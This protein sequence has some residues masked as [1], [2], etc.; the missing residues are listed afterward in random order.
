[1]K[2]FKHEH[3][4]LHWAVFLLTVLAAALVVAPRV[5]ADI[6]PAIEYQYQGTPVEQK[7]TQGG[8]NR[9]N[10]TLNAQKAK[11]TFSSGNAQKQTAT[12]TLKGHH[13]D[14]YGNKTPVNVQTQ[15]ALPK[16]DIYTKAAGGLMGASVAGGALQ[17]Q[18]DGI[19]RALAAG[20]YTTAT[21][22]AVAGLLDGFKGLG[23]S[24]L[25]GGIT[26]AESLING[27][28]QGKQ[29]ASVAEAVAHAQAQ[30]AAEVREANEANSQGL[31]PLATHV[32]KFE[33]GGITTYL[34]YPP[35]AGSTM[36]GGRGDLYFEIRAPNGELVKAV[37]VLSP[38]QSFSFETIFLTPK[39]REQYAQL[40]A[41]SNAP[42]AQQFLLTEQETA[43]A[44]EKALNNLL[45]SQN[46][47]HKELINA[48]W[49]IGA[50]KPANTTTSVLPNS[51]TNNTFLS[52]PYT[53]AGKT[54]AQQ[55][56]IVVAP[57]G[58]I[59]V[60]TVQRPDLAANTSQAPTRQEVGTQANT[61]TERPAKQG[62]T[63]EA[64]DICAQNPNSLMCME[65][66]NADYEDVVIPEDKID[67][68][69]NPADIFNTTAMCPPPVQFSVLGQ[70]Y[71]FEYTPMCSFAE[72]IRPIMILM[73]IIAALSMCY[74]AV[75][76]L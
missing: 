3:L 67:L 2:G 54:V 1:M 58:T 49:A 26:G 28:N 21:Q 57:D 41:A 52:A 27:Y 24:I 6:P 10:L 15:T 75:K 64:P 20:D 37:P 12:T 76:E 44:I 47:N 50:L 8:F 5:Y 61:Q 16:T 7:L 9:E 71:D 68:D 36:G 45:S 48:L 29:P 65:M 66:G 4:L 40:V 69:I 53:P 74:S 55:T 59:T 72:G 18:G 11:E 46:A 35:N 25:G 13:T 51:T 32:L 33:Q 23:N 62:S 17:S 39:N 31:N 63:A 70:T 73:G 14:T 43:N 42:T 22:Y 19:G 34:N 60:S 30:K 56:K 38:P